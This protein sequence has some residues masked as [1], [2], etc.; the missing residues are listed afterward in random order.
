MQE[1]E[2]DIEI[3]SGIPICSKVSHLTCNYCLNKSLNEHNISVCTL[4]VPEKATVITNSSLRCPKGLWAMRSL[5][6]YDLKK[7]RINNYEW[8]VLDLLEAKEKENS[9][10]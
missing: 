5:R 2:F 7:Y 4:L 10:K 8:A 1:K 3:N 9:V 6:D